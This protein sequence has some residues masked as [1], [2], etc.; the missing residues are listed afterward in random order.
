MNIAKIVLASLLFFTCAHSASGQFWQGFLY[1]LGQAAQNYNNQQQY[2]RQQ[3]YNQKEQYNRTT[4]TQINKTRKAE[5]DGYVWYK[6]EQDGDY[7]IEN[8]NGNVILSPNYDYIS[9]DEDGQIFIIHDDKYR[10]ALSKSG[11]WIIPLSRR[12]EK[13]LYMPGVYYVSKNGYE[14]ACNPNGVEVIAPNKYTDLLYSSGEFK[15]KNSSDEWVGLNIGIDGKPIKQKEENVVPS[16]QSPKSNSDIDFFE[17]TKEFFKTPKTYSVESYTN[18]LLGIDGVKLCNVGEST[19]EVNHNSYYLK[20]EDGSGSPKHFN[21]IIQNVNVMIS[22][23]SIVSLPMFICS[24]DYAVRVAR[25]PDGHYM[26]MEYI[27]NQPTGNYLHFFTINLRNTDI[28]S[29]SNYNASTGS[30]TSTKK[31]NEKSTKSFK[32]YGEKIS[33]T[34]IGTGTL[35]LNG[36]FIE[37]Y[38]NIALKISR[39]NDNTVKVAVT[40]SNGVDFFSEPATYTIT[41]DANSNYSLTH[42]EINK[43]TIKIDRYKKAIYRHPCVNIDGDIYTLKITATLK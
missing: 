26:V 24:D 1:G 6:L 38:K 19:F 20:Y 8:T 35:T 33:G 5:S 9:Y 40:E 2:N 30:N 11:N 13:I 10:G 7:G 31:L 28:S 34:Y 15:Y 18:M 23:G 29:S 21:P 17:A 14:G 42:N 25:F 3:Q 43:A 4:E 36:Q 41:K 12:Y 37:S 32:N 39:I 27:K 22:N 16:S